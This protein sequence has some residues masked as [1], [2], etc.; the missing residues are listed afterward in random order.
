MAIL[1]QYSSLP[2]KESMSSD[3]DLKKDIIKKRQINGP[4][5]GK[6][7]KPFS[8][9]I[10]YILFPSAFFDLAATALQDM[11]LIMTNAGS[12]QILQGAIQIYS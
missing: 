5:Q 4:D 9:R 12:F 11:A 1:F 3:E 2:E 8:W 10:S 6:N 7:L